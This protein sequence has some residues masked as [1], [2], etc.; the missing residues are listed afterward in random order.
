MNTRNRIWI[1]AL[2][3][4][5]MLICPISAYSQLLVEFKAI[6][7]REEQQS[8]DRLQA[9]RIVDQVVELVDTT[10]DVDAKIGLVFGGDEGPLFDPD[11][12]I[13]QIP[14][15]F[16]KEVD[17]R[18]SQSEPALEEVE[19]QQAIDGAIAHTLLHEIGHALVFANAL[20]VLGK[21]ED[22]VDSFATL[23][24]L[25]GFD[26]GTQMALDA[27]WLFALEDQEVDEFHDDDFW[28]EHSLGY[29]TLL[30]NA[31]FGLW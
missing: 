2:L 13:I 1:Q 10:L 21:E 19:K 8:L 31:V 11:L 12:E 6:D 20:P 26:N 27:A 29:S 15:A 5:M 30:P 18:F 25:E 23:W 4:V 28:D 24:L 17:N 14:Y 3:P 22:A 16:I 7:S 9:N